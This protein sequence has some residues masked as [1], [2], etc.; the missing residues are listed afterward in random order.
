MTTATS[1]FGAYL[2]QP[3]GSDLLIACGNDP[4]NENGSQ[5]FRSADG[6]TFTHEYTPVEQGSLVD[7]QLVGSEWWCCG[8]DPTEDWSLGNLYKRSSAG[9]W[10]KTRTLPNVIHTFGLWHDGTSIYVA[11]GAHIGDNATWRGRVLRS[12]DGGATWTA[13]EVNNYR[14]YDVMGF[15]GRLYAIGY[16]WTGSTYTRDLHVSADAG[17]TW[18]KINGVAPATKPRLVVFDGKLVVIQSSLTGVYVIQAGG[19]LISYTAPFTLV[20]QW[21]AMADGGDGY[22]YS[23]ASDGVW[24]TSN[25][26]DWQYVVDTGNL[27]SLV[28]WPGVGVMVS[29]MGTAARILKVVI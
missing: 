15:D 2:M 23:L 25:F 1:K 21:N 7:G 29:E 10:T 16:D 6:V 26:T 18:S 14:C 3:L 17:A 24:R 4:A 12:T 9:M 19:T 13:A 27:I 11:V 28:T 5:I 20:N 22:L 8:I